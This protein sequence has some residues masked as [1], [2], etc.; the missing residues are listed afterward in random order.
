MRTHPE[1]GADQSSLASVESS[2]DV[3]SGRPK[4]FR[5][6]HEPR[7]SERPMESLSESVGRC[8]LVATQPPPL[9]LL[10]L[11]DHGDL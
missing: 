1:Y 5:E 9:Y 6:K 4:A 2:T 10:G 3:A 8:C 11:G 7:T